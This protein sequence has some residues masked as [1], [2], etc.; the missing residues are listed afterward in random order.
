MSG[1]ILKALVLAAAGFIVL[2]AS[3]TPVV[4]ADCQ[5]PCKP[6]HMAHSRPQKDRVA[7]KIIGNGS[8]IAENHRSSMASKII[9]NG[10]RE[11]PGA[12]V[13]R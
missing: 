4:P 6:G 11:D 10:Y 9:G 7:S 2:G 1:S 12:M 5:A 3:M 13:A 8:P